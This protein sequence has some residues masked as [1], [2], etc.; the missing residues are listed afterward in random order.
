MLTLQVKTQ[1]YGEQVTMRF[2][3]AKNVQ[4]AING[5]QQYMQQKEGVDILSL[6]I[7]L[8]IKLVPCND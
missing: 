2:R 6:K 4:E 3:N 8:D 5:M 7:P 1:L